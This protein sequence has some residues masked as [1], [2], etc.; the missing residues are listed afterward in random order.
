MS[1]SKGLGPSQRW[2]FGLAGKEIRGHW[3]EKEIM[4]DVSR[5]KQDRHGS[6]IDFVL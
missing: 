2:V 4:V 3:R 6:P 1:W 5:K